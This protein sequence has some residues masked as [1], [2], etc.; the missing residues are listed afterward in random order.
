MGETSLLAGAGSDPTAHKEAVDKKKMESIER[1]AGEVKAKVSQAMS[2]ES[3]LILGQQSE[4][5]T[6]TVR[7]RGTQMVIMTVV[8]LAVIVA[9]GFLMWNR[10]NYYEKKHF[11]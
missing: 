6:K 10:M 8:L 9:I 3:L 5:I 2:K 4:S 1:S 7:V 11:T